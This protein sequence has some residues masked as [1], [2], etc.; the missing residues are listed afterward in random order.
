M[1]P[2][3]SS[4]GFLPVRCP[5]LLF[6]VLYLDGVK[7]HLP[8]ALPLSQMVGSGDVK[9]AML[10]SF[11]TKQIITG[12]VAGYVAPG[13]TV[14]VVMVLSNGVV[15]NLVAVLPKSADQPKDP[16]PPQLE[17]VRGDR[18]GIVKLSNNQVT[19]KLRRASHLSCGAEVQGLV[20]HQ[21]CE[22]SSRVTGVDKN[23][24]LITTVCKTRPFQP[25]ENLDAPDDRFG[26][27]VVDDI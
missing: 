3:P 2:A 23:A 24:S 15:P 4:I 18:H 26:V 8:G 14:L 1:S 10:V 12:D 27:G 7:G 25:V 9:C 11:N 16:Q 17:I 13:S 5:V 21:G 19:T 20:A 22:T 6:T